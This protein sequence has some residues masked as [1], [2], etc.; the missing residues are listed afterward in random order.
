MI[1]VG[2]SVLLVMPVNSHH[3]N[4]EYISMINTLQPDKYKFCAST[5]A[6]K[7]YIFFGDVYKNPFLD[8]VA[9]GM[10]LRD[11]K[12]GFGHNNDGVYINL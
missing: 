7:Y 5:C 1:D 9:N 10:E 2:Q 3:D 8:S 11:L 4:I 6:T 12:D